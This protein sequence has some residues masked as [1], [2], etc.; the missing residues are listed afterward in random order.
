M[1]LHKSTPAGT[2]VVPVPD[3]DEVKVGTLL[4]IIRLSGLPRSLFEA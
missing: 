2:V 1:S 3:H 4:S